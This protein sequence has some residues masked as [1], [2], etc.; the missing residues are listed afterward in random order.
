MKHSLT[1]KTAVVPPA[2]VTATETDA[3]AIEARLMPYVI[4]MLAA[5][6]KSYPLAGL[7]K[8]GTIALALQKAK[9]NTGIFPSTFS[10]TEFESFWI[11]RAIFG[12]LKTILADLTKKADDSYTAYGILASDATN[13]VLGYFQMAVESNPD[14]EDDLEELS[15]FF[16][17]GKRV[18]PASFNVPKSGNM[19]VNNCV[20][21]RVVTNTGT[22]RLALAAGGELT[23]GVKRVA[24]IIIEPNTSAKIPAG[25]TSINI[26][27]LST[28]DSGSFTVKVK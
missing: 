22:T 25:Y 14:L 24:T 10:I 4:E 28:T 17:R 18:P 3:A 1:K 6:K 13:N 27:N 15:Q 2:D 16:K 19:D 12:H 5:Q 23:A 21:G 26:S 8:D 7:K 20:P 9:D 11:N